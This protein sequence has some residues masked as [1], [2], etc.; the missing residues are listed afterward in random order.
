VAEFS[1]HNYFAYHE[2]IDKTRS[3]SLVQ[4]NVL[5]RDLTFR[6]DET[7]IV[8]VKVAIAMIPADIRL[9][10]KHNVYSFVSSCS[11]N[12]RTFVLSTAQV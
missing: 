10:I 6:Y 11:G 5:S 9:R 8:V 7:L 4:S 3:L 1:Y 2:F 12:T